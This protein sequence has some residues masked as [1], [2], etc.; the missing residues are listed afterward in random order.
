MML[1]DE[2]V[3]LDLADLKGEGVLL[4]TEQALGN[5][6]RDDI[7]DVVFLKPDVFDARAT[8][9]IAEELEGI[10]RELVAEGTPYLLIGFGRW[11][12]SDPWLG[13]PVDWGQISG[14]RV[15][16][17]ASRP[18]MIFDMSQGSHFFHNVISFRVLYLSLKH[19]GPYAIDWD[20]LTAQTSVRETAHVRHARLAAPLTVKVDGRGGR[21]VIRR[22]R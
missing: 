12:S 19:T 10:N 4:A 1:P 5:G 20:W 16:V 6:A 18:D 11:G 3:S 15:I 7:R 8:R 17:E 9:E 22:E 21:G 14:A 13:V 2:A